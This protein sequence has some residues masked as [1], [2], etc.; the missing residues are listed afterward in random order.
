[1][2]TL[3]ED[4]TAIVNAHEAEIKAKVA[5]AKKALNEAVELA[6]TYGIPFRPSISFLSNSY[7]PQSFDEG[8]FAELDSDVVADLTGAWR[9]DTYSGW[10]HSA[11]C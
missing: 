7:F 5:E 2:S 11:V 10:Q 9:E 8:K 1:M 3:E 4:F 6:K